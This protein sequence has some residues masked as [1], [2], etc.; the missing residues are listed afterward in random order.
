MSIKATNRCD[1]SYD[2][3]GPPI[4]MGSK[5]EVYWP[6]DDSVC[7]GILTE[8]CHDNRISAQYNDNDEGTGLFM[9]AETWLFHSL[10]A[11][12]VQVGASLKS[13]EQFV[14]Q[15]MFSVLRNKLFCIIMD[16]HSISF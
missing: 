5:I 13:S 12:A 6:D 8:I 4:I 7:A 15:A 14:L 11:N 10:S 1:D 16:K 9:T 3:D 2:S